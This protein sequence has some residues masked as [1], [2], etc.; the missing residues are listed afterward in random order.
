MELS[1]MIVLLFVTSHLSNKVTYKYDIAIIS[2]TTLFI[3]DVRGVKWISSPKHPHDSIL[4]MT[5]GKNRFTPVR[6]VKNDNMATKA[7]DEI[8]GNS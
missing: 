2:N 4:P 5:V 6:Y 3:K 8:T 1:C 7:N